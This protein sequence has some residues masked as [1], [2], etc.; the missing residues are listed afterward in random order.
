MRHSS[1]VSVAIVVLIAAWAFLPSV[2]AA[3]ES[4]PLPASTGFNYFATAIFGLAILHTF[5]ASRFMRLSHRMEQEHREHVL[6]KG[7]AAEIAEVADAKAE[8]SFKA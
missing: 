1:R 8:V 7:T 3:A 2:H 5:L 6:S 4:I